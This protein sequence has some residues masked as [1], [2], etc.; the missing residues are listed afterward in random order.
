M[1]TQYLPYW[2]NKI[3]EHSAIWIAIF[4]RQHQYVLVNERYAELSGFTT[5]EM[6]GMDDKHIFNEEVYQQLKPY[7]D[8]AFHGETINTEI[9]IDWLGFATHLHISLS[10]IFHEEHPDYILFQ[11]TDE[12]E[13]HTLQ[14]SL[15]ETEHRFLALSQLLPLGV[16]LVEEDYI[17]SANSSAIQLLGYNESQSLL[18]ESLSQLFIDE[19]TQQP[20]DSSI[21]DKLIHEPFFCLTGPRCGGERRIQLRATQTTLFRQPAYLVVIQDAEQTAHPLVSPQQNTHVDPLTGVNNRLG[22]TKRLD[23]FIDNQIPLVMLY[24]DID[25]FKNINDSLGHHIGDKVI[26][27]VSSRL[28]RLLPPQAVLGHLGGDEFGLI[29]PEPE[30]EKVGER[31]AD[32]IITL[33]NQ[34]FDLHHFS[35]RLA[36]S[37]GCVQFPG[38]GN[39]ARVLLQNA[40]TAMYEAKE[41]GRNR[42]ITFNNQMNKEARMRLWLEIEL[43]KALQQN[44]LEVWYQPKVN[45]RDFSIN[46]AE[47]LVRWKH[48]IEGYISPGAFIP[49]AEKAG[50]IEHLGRVV[51]REVFVTVKRWQQQNILPGKVA[52]NISPEQFGNAHLIHH[53][54]KLLQQTGVDP[55]CI[56]FELTES[57]V[58]SDSAHTLQMLNAIKKL[59]FSLSIDD[60]GTGYSSLAYLARFPIDELKIDRTFIADIDTLPKQVTVIESIIKLGKALNL[61]VVAEGVETQEQA[62]LLSHLHCHTIQGFHFYRPKPKYEVEELF[63]QH[64]R[65]PINIE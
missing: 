7:Y 13:K 56:T 49:V 52:I 46:G 60:F 8:R 15:K 48:P 11:A 1:P 35:K 45:A 44:G 10:P 55:S 12:S 38:D 27:E 21:M 19:L 22:F 24:L 36:C 25:N 30:H 62:T 17:L 64:R 18:G 54:E 14:H 43:Q 57:A 29:I 65:S 23:H 32:R 4:D 39:N 16:L 2:F 53:L 20:F 63:A 28:K 59:G 5:F 51:I 50:L 26:K 33:I 3:T 42:W 47:A 31:L 40:D 58:M 41:R 37:I 61:S 9:E 6:V 34:P